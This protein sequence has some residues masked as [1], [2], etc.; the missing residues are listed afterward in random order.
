[1]DSTGANT[2]TVDAVN[3]NNSLFICSANITTAIPTG[4]SITGT[5]PTHTTTN[6]ATFDEFPGVLT[7]KAPKRAIFCFRTN[8]SV[9]SGSITTTQANDLLFG[10]VSMGS[11]ATFTASSVTPPWNATASVTANG[12]SIYS[13]QRPVFATGTYSLTGTTSG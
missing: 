3:G 9:N 2:W 6:A 1:S 8:N 10:W 11:A 12:K 13:Y 5:L 4:G 7:P